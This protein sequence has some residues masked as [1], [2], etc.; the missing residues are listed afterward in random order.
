MPY[1]VE[2]AHDFLGGVA[3]QTWA[4]GGSCFAVE[5]LG[6]GAL[7]GSAWVSSPPEDGFGAAGF[8]TAPASRGSGLTA[9]VLGVLAGCALGG[10]GLR[11]VELH[12]DPAN[13]GSRRVAEA[14]GFAAEGTIRRRFLHRGRPSD[15]VLYARLAGDRGAGPPGE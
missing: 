9:E 14:A 3:P 10:A 12:V 8:W 5:P 6:G 4:D 13:S 11:R 1:A 7:V 15:V 2:H